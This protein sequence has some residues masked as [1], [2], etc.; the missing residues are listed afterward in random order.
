MVE[1]SAEAMTQVNSNSEIYYAFL[2][3]SK[4]Y[5][6]GTLVNKIPKI[7]YSE[8]QRVVSIKYNDNVY[9]LQMQ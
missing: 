4:Y 2:E 5:Y 6:L 1:E 8:A 9:E 7:L 3:S